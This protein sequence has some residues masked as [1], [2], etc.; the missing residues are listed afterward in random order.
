[1]RRYY[2]V[3]IMASRYHGTLYV[4]VTSALID[5]AHQHREGLIDGFT[6]T[7]NVKLLVYYEM[8]ED[9]SNAINREK[10]IKR[11]RRAW[12]IK[13]IEEKTPHWHDLFDKLSDELPMA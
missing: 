9:P 10:L 8:H 3:Y 5:H 1:M 7:H 6:K 4:G 11:W 12:K 13:L 2:Y